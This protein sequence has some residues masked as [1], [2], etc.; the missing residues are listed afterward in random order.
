MEIVT[1]TFFFLYVLVKGTSALGNVIVVFV[2][3]RG[4]SSASGN[5]IAAF[6]LERSRIKLMPF[7]RKLTS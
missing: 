2:L 4:T 5:V 6:V 1:V 7:S 3:V